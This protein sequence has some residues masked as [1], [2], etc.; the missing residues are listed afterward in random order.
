MQDKWQEQIAYLQNEIR[1]RDELLE[2]DYDSADE[3]FINSDCGLEQDPD[4]D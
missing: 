4:Q 2:D 1:K 3:S